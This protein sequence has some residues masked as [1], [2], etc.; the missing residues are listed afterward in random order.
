MVIDWKKLNISPSPADFARPPQSVNNQNSR[1]V[2]SNRHKM[3]KDIGVCT[4][5]EI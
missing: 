3:V 1:V 4:P 2:R 5:K